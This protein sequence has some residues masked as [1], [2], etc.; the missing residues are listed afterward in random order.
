[1]SEESFDERPKRAARRMRELLL[2]PRPLVVC[3]HR[4]LMPALVEAI[5]SLRITGPFDLDPKLPP[6]GF[7]VVHRQFSQDGEEPTVLAVE[8]HSVS[9]D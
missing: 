7:L 2:D 6:G 3:T 5:A 8:R 1:L 9:R 4:P